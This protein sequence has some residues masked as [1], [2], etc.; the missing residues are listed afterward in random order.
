MADR[1]R[2]EACVCTGVF[3]AVRHEHQPEMLV[4]KCKR[5]VL[6]MRDE[7]FERFSCFMFS[8]LKEFLARSR[9]LGLRHLPTSPSASPKYS[10]SL[11]EFTGCGSLLLR[12][13]AAKGC[14][15]QLTWGED[16]LV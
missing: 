7:P 5:S 9:C 15:A 16:S 3:Q 2:I 6:G 8:V 1:A 10:D 14:Q 4:S 11:G 13:I 12:N